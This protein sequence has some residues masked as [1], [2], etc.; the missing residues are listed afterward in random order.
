M[1]TEIPLHVSIPV[2]SL[3]P[4]GSTAPRWSFQRVATAVLGFWVAV[5]ALLGAVVW[6][7]VWDLRP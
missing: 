5:A 4:R 3:P 6:V 2:S 1:T 7:I